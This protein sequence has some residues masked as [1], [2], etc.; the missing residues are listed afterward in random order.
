MRLP[1]DATKLML[2]VFFP[3]L[4]R[5]EIK[6]ERGSL[7]EGPL[8]VAANHLSNYDIPLL[9][10]SI[11]RRISFM[12]QE[13]LYRFPFGVGFRLFDSFPIHRGRV[14][15]QAFDKV[16]EVLSREDWALGMFPEGRK[17]PTAQLQPAHPG[18]ALIALQSDA[19][20]LP[21][22]ISG[23]EKVKERIERPTSFF[24]RPLVTA[25]IGKPFKLPQQADGKMTRG[26]LKSCA[27]IIMAKLCE[28]LPQ[29]YHGVYAHGEQTSHTESPVRATISQ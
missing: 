6:G 8:I 21:V 3:L 15:R 10:I 1:Y 22:G 24:H 28:L 7:P 18:T 2:P 19:Y 23:T 26:H 29:A 25:S 14:D 13:E 27:D 5:W 16:N 12:G 11:S 9:V 4:C 20:I 17:S